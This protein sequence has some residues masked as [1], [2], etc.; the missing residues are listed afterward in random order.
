[1][2]LLAT[3]VASAPLVLSAALP[4]A[5]LPEGAPAADDPPTSDADTAVAPSVSLVRQPAWTRIGGALPMRLNVAGDTT[6][7]VL[8]F[9][10]YGRLSSRSAFELTT[11]D[12]GLGSQVAA[13]DLPLDG[14]AVS[15]DGEVVAR[16][17]LRGPDEQRDPERLPISMTGVHPLRVALVD[18]GSGAA[19]SD[20]VTWI[21]A[22]D[23]DPVDTPLA[24][25]WVWHVSAPPLALPD[26]SPEPAVLSQMEPGGRL[27]VIAGLLAET[28]GL[29]VSIML[30][31]ETL[32]SWRVAA[33]DDPDLAAGYSALSAAASRSENQ[34]LPTPY[35][36]IEVPDL[37][38]A[39]L[40]EELVPELIAGS[41]TLERILDRRV[42]P[43]TAFVDPVDPDAID[44]LRS[45]FVDRIVVREESL[46][47]SE[48][49][50]T[51]ARPFSL[52]TGSLDVVAAATNP[53]LYALLEGDLPD[54][55]L[56]QRFLAGVA[57][58]ALEAPADQ[59]GLVFSTP[60]E[61][62]PRGETISLLL[63]GLREHPLVDPMTLDDYFATVPLDTFDDSEEPLIRLLAGFEPGEHPVT[64]AQLADARLTLDS[65][66]TVVGDDDDRIRR[67]EHAL[68]TSLTTLW[69]SDRAAAELAVIDDAATRFLSGITMTEQ[70][71][72]VTSR[73][74]N[75]PLSFV[76]DTGRPVRVRVHLES[77]KLV[78]PE[79]SDRVVELAEGNTTE[80]FLLSARA[81]G[82]FTM[83]VTLTSE[84]GRLAVGSPESITVHATVF[85]GVGAFLT[86]GALIFL[87]GWWA[88]HI[89]RG[90]RERRRHDSPGTPEEPAPAS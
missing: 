74:A 50:L 23:D 25:S 71:V 47:P 83:S 78:F 87:A 20:F 7:L 11:L 64:P 55:L 57:L 70:S 12:Q 10:L 31:P 9:T 2:R 5:G 45:S 61:W 14:K 21:V 86:I 68:L 26:G 19:L 56:A 63:E 38:S 53:G 51:P 34:L 60:S 72:T 28:R 59:R 32:D 27:D 36:P 33:R 37:V 80:R 62:D 52:A 81:N 43:R 75:V 77:S 1:M 30:S 69:S 24:F 8:R 76:N 89:W 46:L 49:N 73:R 17:G 66:R 39:G 44:R 41:D 35:V 84:D 67:G 3:F 16:I 18:S 65:F 79:G 88:N 6:G 90:R 82:T 48:R 54:A 4:V 13:V 42:D 40:G 15:D 58:V 22:V 85:S 29:P